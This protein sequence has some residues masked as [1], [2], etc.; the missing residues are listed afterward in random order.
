MSYSTAGFRKSQHIYLKHFHPAWMEV[1]QNN[2]AHAFGVC[3]KNMSVSLAVL[4]NQTV[5]MNTLSQ[6]RPH[7]SGLMKHAG[8]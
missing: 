1:L 4:L 2:T 7:L 6:P 8:C 3:L 5:L